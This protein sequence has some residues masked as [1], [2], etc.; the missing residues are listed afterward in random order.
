MLA[1]FDPETVDHLRRHSS[2][3]SIEVKK[4]QARMFKQFAALDSVFKQ[5]AAVCFLLDAKIKAGV[6]H[7]VSK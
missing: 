7:F 1:L 2:S 5:Y 6:A 3:S 4:V